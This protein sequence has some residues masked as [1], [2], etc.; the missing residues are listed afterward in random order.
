MV[1][2]KQVGADRVEL[3][4]EPYAASFGTATNDACLA[5]YVGTAN[6]AIEQGLSYDVYL[7]PDDY[8]HKPFPLTTNTTT[9]TRQY[10][11]KESRNACRLS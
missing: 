11:Q 3:Y 9:F 4:T 6:A 8:N 2:V 1:F 10:L 7:K 5:E